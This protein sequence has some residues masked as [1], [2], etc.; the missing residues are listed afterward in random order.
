METYSYYLTQLSSYFG[1]VKKRQK[2]QNG[3]KHHS[4]RNY[5]ARIMTE[6]NVFSFRRNLKELAFTPMPA[7]LAKKEDLIRRIHQV[8]K[9]F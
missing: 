7:S 3:R 1:S 8:V 5:G 6:I 2:S 4:Q 9:Y